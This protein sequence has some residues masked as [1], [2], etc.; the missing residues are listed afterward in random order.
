ME[1]QPGPVGTDK[2]R[3]EALL[4]KLEQYRRSTR[5]EIKN[6]GFGQLGPKLH[7]AALGVRTELLR[8]HPSG[9]KLCSDSLIEKQRITIYT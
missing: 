6:G 2:G 4:K 3:D 9:R 8:L 5:K 1:Q 7:G